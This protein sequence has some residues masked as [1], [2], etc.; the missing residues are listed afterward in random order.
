MKR[1]CWLSLSLLALN[2]QAADAYRLDA[3]HTSVSF[4]V[5]RFGIPWVDAHFSQ[6]SGDFVVDRQG[7]DSHI[8]VTV[9]TDS[10]EGL[11]SGW[12]TRLRSSDWLDTQHFPEMSYRSSHV[13]FDNSGGAV[14]SGQLTL[15]G[16][17]RPVTL[18]V[19]RLD[20][21][22]EST[23]PDH[24]CGFAARAN[25]KRSDFGLP[26]GFWL[27]GDQVEISVNGA[28][29]RSEHR[30]ASAGALMPQGN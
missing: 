17:T 22:G 25:I 29:L 26:H 9:R 21:S 5:R 6:F 23:V 18:H 4:D 7:T 28:A 30:L 12:S 27:A 13:E 20:C 16:I 3:D 8:D 14:A 11:N 10:I 1:T 15:H 24:P 2:A 19:E